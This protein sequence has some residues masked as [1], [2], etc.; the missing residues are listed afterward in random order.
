MSQGEKPVANV[1][2][3]KSGLVFE[4]DRGA[5]RSFWIASAILVFI[6]LW[7]G[8]G[9]MGEDEPQSGVEKSETAPQLVAVSVRTSVAEPVML[10]FQAEGQAEPDRDSQ[11]RAEASGEVAQILAQP[12]Q[13]VERGDPIA[14]L[15]PVQAEADLRRAL[16]DLESAQR[17]LENA[18]SLRDRGVATEDR[19]VDARATLASNEAEVT[20]A[21]E[22]LARTNIIAPFDGRI[23]ALL[24]DEG[25]FVSTGAEIGR[26]VDITPLTVSLEVPQQS[27]SQIRVNQEAEV[28]FITGEVRKGEVTFVGTSASSETR[29]FLTEIEV[30]NVDGTIPA[31]ISAEVN[32]PTGEELAHFITPSVVSLNPTGIPG[33]KTVENN[34]VVFY[35]ITVVQAD[36]DG[37]WVTGLPDEIDLITI[38]Q[39]FVRE[40]EIVDPQP[41]V[42][43]QSEGASQ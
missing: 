30:E 20:S 41:E 23:E 12:G 9:F 29:T 38:G 16:E 1:Q 27:L 37:F 4:T 21:Q 14:R 13:D 5:Q 32:I 2:T 11:I 33:V 6:V 15:S 35:E 34:E 24:I 36:V 3:D 19:V 28:T 17:E 26:I 10:S 22:A 39:G 31:G 25:E 40:G 8:S 18:Q 7:M 42:T 43:R